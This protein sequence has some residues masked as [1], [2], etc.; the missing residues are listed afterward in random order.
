VQQSTEMESKDDQYGS[1]MIDSNES[2]TDV[3]HEKAE[4]E[5]EGQ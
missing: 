4:F 3:T 1:F 2:T 5:D